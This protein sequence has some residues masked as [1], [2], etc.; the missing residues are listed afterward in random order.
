MGQLFSNFDSISDCCAG[1]KQVSYFP[2]LG[3]L[4]YT[5]DWAEYQDQITNGIENIGYKW[6]QKVIK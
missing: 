2:I 3:N 6:E 5:R 4:P 1:R